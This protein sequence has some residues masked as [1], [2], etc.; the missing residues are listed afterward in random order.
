MDS[1]ELLLGRHS[2]TNQGSLFKRNVSL[3]VLD[4]AVNRSVL[5][6]TPND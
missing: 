1:A 6:A 5:A 2:L 4:A 3:L